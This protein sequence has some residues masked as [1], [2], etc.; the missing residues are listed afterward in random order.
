MAAIS[1]RKP[2]NPPVFRPLRRQTGAR[3]MP[4]G[5]EMGHSEPDLHRLGPKTARKGGAKAGFLNTSGRM[6]TLSG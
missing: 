4:G 1:G 3:E 6:C 2:G 5:T